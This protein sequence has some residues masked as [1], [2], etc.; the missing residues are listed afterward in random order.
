MAG[1]DELPALPP[2]DCGDGWDWMDELA[3]TPWVPVPNWGRDGWDLGHWPYVIICVCAPATKA[4]A[5]GV[6]T[7]VEGDRERYAF[8]THA[9]MIRR[10]DEIAAFYWRLSGVM[11]EVPPIGPVLEKHTGPFSWERHDVAKQEGR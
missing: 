10:V 7:Y 8:D 4:K 9:E 1:L 5:F 6:A 2:R 11:E 3:D